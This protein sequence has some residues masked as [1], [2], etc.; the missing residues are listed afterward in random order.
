MPHQ[1]EIQLGV[2]EVYKDCGPRDFGSRVLGIY[3]ELHVKL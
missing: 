3:V 2:F 1:F